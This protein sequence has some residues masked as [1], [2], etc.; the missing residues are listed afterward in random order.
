MSKAVLA[1]HFRVLFLCGV[2]GFCGLM[3]CVILLFFN[4]VIELP[5]L[6]VTA[7]EAE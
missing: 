3:L 5:N 1:A 7:A 4:R 2:C 6:C